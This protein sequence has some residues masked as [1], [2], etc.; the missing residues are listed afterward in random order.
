MHPKCPRDLLRVDAKDLRLCGEARLSMAHL[1][2]YSVQWLTVWEIPSTYENVSVLNA[3]LFPFK[4]TL[5]GFPEF[6][7][8]MCTNREILHLRPNNRGWGTSD[9]RKGVFLNEKGREAAAK[10]REAVGP[11]SFDGEVVPSEAPLADSGRSAKRTYSPAQ[12][13]RERRSR[14]LFR[15]FKEGRLEE[16]DVVH[17]LGLLGLYDHTR[18]V[19]LR[20][21]FKRLRDVASSLRDEEFLSFLDAVQKQFRAY[22]ERQDTLHGRK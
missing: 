3:R 8:A 17:L 19:E 22:L 12:D 21:E 14:L 20:R 16:A 9:P 11:P 10:V 2:A 13:L 1:T 5:A 7:D 4:F 6:P 18:P 15:W